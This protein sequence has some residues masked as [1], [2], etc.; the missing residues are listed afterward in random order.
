[1]IEA[2]H[3][4]TAP[5][6]GALT[7]E[8]WAYGLHGIQ[9]P[10]D[11][12]MARHAVADALRASGLECDVAILLVS[13]LVTNALEA[14]PEGG[15]VAIRFRLTDSVLRVDVIDGAPGRP[16][17]EG[18]PDPK[19]IRGRGLALV[20]ELADHC[21]VEPTERPGKCTWFDMRPGVAA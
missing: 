15:R 12:S 2:G 14:T 10:S 1:M 16:A 9:R 4:T 18:M 5:S 19:S 8:E 17:T 6:P 20:Q 11:V 21:G 3:T 7:H 13:E